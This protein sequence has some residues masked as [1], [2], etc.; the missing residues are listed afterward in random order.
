[1]SHA[2]VPKETSQE[3]DVVA[4]TQNAS[5]WEVEAEDHKFKVIP[6]YR[7]RLLSKKKE[8]RGRQVNNK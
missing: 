7:V 5:T 2:Q 8:T 6:G 4:D 3:P 1:M